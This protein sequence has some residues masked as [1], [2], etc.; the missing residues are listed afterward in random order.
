MC[1]QLGRTPRPLSVAL[2]SPVK[3]HLLQLPR[4]SIAHGD[5]ARRTLTSGHGTRNEDIPA[6]LARVFSHSSSSLSFTNQYVGCVASSVSIPRPNVLI[7]YCSQGMHNRKRLDVMFRQLGRSHSFRTR[8]FNFLNWLCDVIILPPSHTSSTLH[9]WCRSIPFLCPDK[10]MAALATW[11][12]SAVVGS[13]RCTSTHLGY[14]DGSS[15]PCIERY[16]LY[17]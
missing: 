4:I 8:Y 7:T 10:D 13:Y 15:S 6:P 1:L 14:F 17:T 5:R 12:A 3:F 11:A 9:N 2:Y 16:I